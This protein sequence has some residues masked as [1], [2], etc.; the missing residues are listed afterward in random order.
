MLK[1]RVFGSTYSCGLG[2]KVQRKGGLQVST[3]RRQSMVRVSTRRHTFGVGV[4]PYADGVIFL[5][6]S[7]CMLLSS[8]RWHLLSET[9]LDRFFAKS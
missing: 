7:S 4:G 2:R 9:S 8:G 6:I 1:I 5:G 3:K